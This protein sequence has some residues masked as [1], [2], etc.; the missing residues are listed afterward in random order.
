MSR[1]FEQFIR[2]FFLK[3]T[4]NV[5]H[6]LGIILEHFGLCVRKHTFILPSCLVLRAKVYLNIGV[7]LIKS[8][9]TFIE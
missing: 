5:T 1:C 2:L 4:T 7:N 9:V 8:T 6:D 3:L